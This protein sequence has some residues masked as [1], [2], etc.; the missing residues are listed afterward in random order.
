MKQGI[1]YIGQLVLWGMMGG[2][3]LCGF[4]HSVLAQSTKS[5]QHVMQQ[6]SKSDHRKSMAV[7]TTRPALQKRVN[8]PV[9]P[10]VGPTKRMTLALLRFR[11]LREVIQM[12]EWA[13]ERGWLENLDIDQLKQVDQWLNGRFASLLGIQWQKGLWLHVQGTNQPIQLQTSWPVWLPPSY[14]RTWGRILNK[15]QQVD[16]TL[17]IPIQKTFWLGFAIQQILG[18]ARVPFY[19]SKYNN[20][21]SYWLFPPRGI[22]AILILG[23]QHI[24]VRLL[25]PRAMIHTEA[26][27]LAI[28]KNIL[29]PS[30][31]TTG[32]GFVQAQTRMRTA[33]SK[34]S[35]VAFYLAVAESLAWLKTFPSRRLRLLYEQ[36]SHIEGLGWEGTLTLSAFSMKSVEWY[37]QRKPFR[38]TTT[39]LSK[40][41]TPNNHPVLAGSPQDKLPVKAGGVANSRRGQG[42][43]GQKHNPTSAMSGSR[44]AHKTPGM[45]V[46]LQT[47]PKGLPLPNPL[48]RRTQSAPQGQSR[49]DPFARIAAPNTP[50]SSTAKPGHVSSRVGQASAR[51][52][53]LTVVSQQPVQPLP[54]EFVTWPSER[55]VFFGSFSQSKSSIQPRSVLIRRLF[56]H[57]HNEDSQTDIL[58]N[59]LHHIHQVWSPSGEY[60]SLW[61]DQRQMALWILESMMFQQ[62]MLWGELEGGRPIPR[63]SGSPSALPPRGSRIQV[64]RGGEKPESVPTQNQSG[65]VKIAAVGRWHVSSR[66]WLIP[67]WKKLATQVTRSGQH[68]QLHFSIGADRTPLL[69]TWRDDVWFISDS[70][71]LL[72]QMVRQYQRKERGPFLNKLV[73]DS[74]VYFL[75]QNRQWNL[76]H[77]NP[78]LLQCL[79]Q[80]SF[81]GQ[82]ASLFT[83]K[84]ETVEMATLP[85]KQTYEVHLQVRWNPEKTTT[86]VGLCQPPTRT[87]KHLLPFILSPFQHTFFW[88]FLEQG[89]R[90]LSVPTR[91]P[92]DTG[93]IFRR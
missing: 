39:I 14:I 44:N 32:H 78:A 50:S 11:Q 22:P 24:F 4:G 84:V 41:A 42:S 46:A 77:L 25:W 56:Q 10:L 72:Q 83:Q 80:R 55:A 45:Q 59:L 52:T 87:W 48:W 76:L 79:L 9:Q 92:R 6:K 53:W 12:L 68:M 66:D 75:Q 28:W 18:L 90:L 57:D 8:V 49:R 17:Q 15:L 63:S 51:A 85:Q 69:L 33:L 47:A 21:Q 82:V 26:G 71:Q 67:L 88:Q 34:T 31:V 35:T 62:W 40:P 65:V 54:L 38:V 70:S 2:G 3:V 27:R 86:P 58:A 89:H 60:D 36:F 61:W 93:M 13:V 37:G 74:M 23:Q 29:V 64:K 16:V 1:T 20:T 30:L 91:L 5:A 73:T 81:V 43:T 7:V 19:A